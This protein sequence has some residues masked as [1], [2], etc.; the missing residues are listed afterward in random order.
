MHSLERIQ[1]FL[2]WEL[3]ML[4]IYI[5]AGINLSAL[6]L[7][8]SPVIW[9]WNLKCKLRHLLLEKTKR[10]GQTN[11]QTKKDKVYWGS[12]GGKKEDLVRFL[13]LTKN[14][15]VGPIKSAVSSS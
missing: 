6:L 9:T 3:N 4:N 5:S 12:P 14:F 1:K 13:R 10:K 2:N 15:S 11:K 8:K 7:M